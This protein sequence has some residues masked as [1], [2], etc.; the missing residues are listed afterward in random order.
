MYGLFSATEETN[1]ENEAVNQKLMNQD[2]ADPVIEIDNN[3]NLNTSRSSNITLKDDT[4]LSQRIAMMA[5][6]ENE[7]EPSKRTSKEPSTFEQAMNGADTE[8]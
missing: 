7:F 3:N 4:P 5:S 6:A 1:S 8:K 2:I